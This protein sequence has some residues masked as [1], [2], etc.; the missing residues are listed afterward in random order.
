M[1][2]LD[3][4]PNSVNGDTE[5]RHLTY[6]FALGALHRGK[7]IEQ[8]LGG[9]ERD[10]RQGVRWIAISPDRSGVTVYLSEVVD[11][12]T[13][14]FHDV[15]EFPPLDPDEES[16]GREIA[17]LATPEEA[18]QVAV[19]ELGADPGRWVNQGIVCD[20]YR[21]FRIARKAQSPM[22]P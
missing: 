7:E 8:F 12:G 15:T 13:D 2:R 9:I 18:L 19:Q 17:V 21:D 22:Q 10:G 5:V 16:W 14:T 1:S 20:E 6:V 11:A 3:A 4:S